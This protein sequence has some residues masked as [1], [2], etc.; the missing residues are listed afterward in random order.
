MFVWNPKVRLAQP[1]PYGGDNPK[2]PI[3]NT[4][5]ELNPISTS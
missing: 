2:V 3:I 4:K 1:V 5:N